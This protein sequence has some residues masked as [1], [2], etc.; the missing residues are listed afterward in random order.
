MGL[1]SADA[2]LEF[3]T[4]VVMLDQQLIS[5]ADLQEAA[6]GRDR[7]VGLLH[8]GL[9]VGAFPGSGHHA[10]AGVFIVER[11]AGKL[12]N[13][14]RMDAVILPVTITA[15]EREIVDPVL[16]QPGEESIG[17]MPETAEVSVVVDLLQIIRPDHRRG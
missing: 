16:L 12:V 8:E 1:L 4:R 15:N 17:F 10:H 3:A 6:L 11:T 9:R 14:G 7:G 5:R 2:V 13:A